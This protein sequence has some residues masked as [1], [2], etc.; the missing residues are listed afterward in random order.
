M[1][2]TG[3]AGMIAAA[4]LAG[5]DQQALRSWGD[6]GYP[7]TARRATAEQW[8]ELTATLADESVAWRSGR[9]LAVRDAGFTEVA[10][11]TVT[12]IASAPNAIYLE[13]SP[14]IHR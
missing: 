13:S 11:G 5:D 12:V 1:A 8:H 2:Q 9:M 10:P 7:A 3:H 6:A 14:R 4:L